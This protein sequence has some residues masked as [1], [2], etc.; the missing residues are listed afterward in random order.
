LFIVGQLF[1]SFFKAVAGKIYSE[2]RTVYYGNNAAP[3]FSEGI[4]SIGGAL[5]MFSHSQL[6]VQNGTYI[7]FIS[8]TG[9]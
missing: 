8:N 2:G 7:D 6:I 1:Q 3:N 9:R 5:H 4:V